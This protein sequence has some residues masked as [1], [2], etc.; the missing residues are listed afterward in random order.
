MRR[1]MLAAARGRSSTHADGP[2]LSR[3]LTRAHGGSTVERGSTSNGEELPGGRRC[4]REA[5]P[6]SGV[7]MDDGIDGVQAF[8]RLGTE[9]AGI[10]A[11]KGESNSSWL[12]TG[13]SGRLAMN[14]T[15]GTGGI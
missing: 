5:A 7:D 9:L 14:V 6:V 3:P 1:V 8:G 13:V 12:G 2:H 15:E 11:W 10:T 4:N